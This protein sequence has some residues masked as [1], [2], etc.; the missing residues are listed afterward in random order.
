MA[1][2]NVANYKEQGGSRDV[3]GGSLD[4]VSGGDLD[5]ESGGAFKVAGTAVTA[6][7][8]EL[9]KMDGVTATSTQINYIA[10]TTAGTVEASKA[11]VVGASKDIDGIDVTTTFK[12]NGTQVTATAAQLN[13]AAVTTNGVVEA[14]KVVVV[15]ANKEVDHIQITELMVGAVTITVTGTQINNLAQGVA[16]GA[17]ITGNVVAFTGTVD[18]NTGLASVVS[19]QATQV[20]NPSV[21]DGM[22]VTVVDA[23]TAG[24][25]TVKSWKPTAANNV[26]P[27]AG[28]ASITASWQV[29][30]T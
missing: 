14:N 6:S 17:K 29:I 1:D 15:G 3:I 5:I 11:V 12:L 16:A 22:Y 23:T 13:K 24:W 9:N 7:A 30:G 2:V 18:V 20:S 19:K 26:E 8:A 25:I 10:V 4:V 28:S 27:A 21:T